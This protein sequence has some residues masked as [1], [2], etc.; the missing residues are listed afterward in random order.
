MRRSIAWLALAL[1]L[2]GSPV[3]AQEVDEA[4]RASVRELGYAGIDHYQR[5][6]YAEAFDKLDRSY[7]L[8]QVPTLGLWSARALEKLGR[9]VEASERYFDVMRLPVPPLEAEVHEKAQ[10]EAKVE[11]E[12][13]APR[14]PR[15]TPRLPEGADVAGLTVLL[16]GRPLAPELL[17]AAIPVDPGTRRLVVRR[18]ADERTQEV[19]VAPGA[20]VT[21]TLEVPPIAE[22]PPPASEIAL[23]P[24]PPPLPTPTA[25]PDEGPSPAPGPLTI[26]GWS[27]VG[28][29]GAALLAGAGMGIYLGVER[30]RLDCD[31]QGQCPA[32]EADE[33]DRL[34]G[35]RV[36]TT[37]V[38]VGGVVVAAAGVTLVLV[39]PTPDVAVA[40]TPTGIHVR[41]RFY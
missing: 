19:T 27:L 33:V 17:G 9:W 4:T 18:G 30:G 35:L 7:R 25:P 36:P 6:E 26:A 32:S 24:L 13:L 3:S 16:D 15:V 21:V 39:D 37:V 22:T 31:D 8:L 20:S 1:G 38:L 12:A 11:R 41:G 10:A 2:V 23:P 28:M 40:L 29:G 5:G 14:I 34:N